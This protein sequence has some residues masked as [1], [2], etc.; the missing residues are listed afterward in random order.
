MTADP[1]L[2]AI[3][4]YCAAC[5]DLQADAETDLVEAGLD[6]IRLEELGAFCALR[7]GVDARTLRLRDARTATTLLAWVRSST[8]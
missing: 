5:L 6:S 3:L 2:I 1:D 7:F 4:D 8:G